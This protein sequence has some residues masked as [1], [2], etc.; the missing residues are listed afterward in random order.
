M[1]NIKFVEK[2]SLALAASLAAFGVFAE[3]SATV[4]KVLVRQLWPWSRNVRV[5]YTLANT[6]G[7]SVDISVS[8]YNGSTEL[9]MTNIGSALVSDE[10][11]HGIIGDGIHSFTFD[12]YVLFG[13]D[14]SAYTDFKVSVD[15]AGVG[16]PLSTRI[17]YRVFDLETGAVTTLSRRNIYDHPELYGSTVITNYPDLYSGFVK[18]S[19]LPAE[20]VFIVPGF[21]SNDVFKTTKIVMKRIPAAGNEFW[22]GP[23]EDDTKTPSSDWVYP[24]LGEHRFKAKLSSDFYIGIFELTQKQYQMLTGERPSFYTNETYWATRPLEYAMLADVTAEN[25]FIG[26]AANMFGKAIALPTEAQWEY[27]AKALYD[28]AG[29]P[30]GLELTADNEL[31]ME[32]YASRG[33][34][35]RNDAIG[36]G[37]TYT[38]GLGNPNPFGL[39]NMYGNVVEWTSDKVRTNLA[40][41]YGWESGKGAIEDPKC[42]S[43]QSAFTTS[44]GYNVFKGGSFYSGNSSAERRPAYR[45]ADQATKKLYISNVP[46]YG[47]RLVCPAD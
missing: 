22:M 2:I 25:G 8:A 13:D 39:Y 12:P 20:D 42:D 1:K 37:G 41:Y 6:D 27:A 18:P 21:A 36:I 26:L 4:E 29:Y 47:F 31:V 11:L 14:V 23:S 19:A 5:E 16:D 9:D 17:E 43:S 34:S 3:T 7:G 38:V 44:P 32:H 45:G 10:G 30:S 40:T 33:H 28:G 35:S 15:I 24:R 46:I